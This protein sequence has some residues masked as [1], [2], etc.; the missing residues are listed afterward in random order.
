MEACHTGT[1]FQRGHPGDPFELSDKMHIVFVSAH[2]GQRVN[3][4]IGAEKKIFRVFHPTVYHIIDGAGAELL[5]IDVLK[6]GT[7]EGQ[8]CRHGIDI[9]IQMGLIIDFGAQIGKQMDIGGGV[10]FLIISMVFRYFNKKQANV[11]GEGILPE[12]IAGIFFYANGFDQRRKGRRL[13]HR[14][15]GIQ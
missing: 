9:P 4:H 12:G 7:A 10:R 3:G 13:L 14:K 6:I 8:L 15:G 5:L 1:I 11:E 2:F